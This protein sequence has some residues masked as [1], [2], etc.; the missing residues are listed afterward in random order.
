MGE[1]VGRG[2]GGSELEYVDNLGLV[3]IPENYDGQKELGIGRTVESKTWKW[4]NL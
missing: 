3:A 1:A 2:S 4:D